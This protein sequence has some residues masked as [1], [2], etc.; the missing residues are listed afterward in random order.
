MNSSTSSIRSRMI[1][2]ACSSL[3]LAGCAAVLGAPAAAQES[4]AFLEEIVVVSQK[5]EQTLQSLP[6]AVS[7]VSKQQMDE[8]QILDVKD[9][10]FLVPS[11]RVSQLQSA[12]NTTFLIRGFG[13]GANNAG[14]EP[15]VGVFIDGVYRSR[16]AASLADLPNLER[17]EVIKGPQSTLFGKNASAGVINVVTAKPSLDGYSG[18]VQGTIGEYN[19]IMGR[20]EVNG[21][22]SDTWAWGIAANYNQRDGYFTNLET[23]SEF[24]E[25]NRYGVR[26]QLLWAPSDDFEARFIADMDEIDELCCGVANLFTAPTLLPVIGA[27]GADVVENEPFAYSQFLNFDAQNTIEN[28]GLSLQLDWNVSDNATLTSITAYRQLD[29]FENSDSDFFSGQL[30]DET[31]G[32]RINT[33]L[34]TFTQELR[35]AGSNE[36]VDW[37][38]GAFFFDEDVDQ[39]RDLT[40]GSQIR[41]YFDIL[42]GDGLAPVE[43]VANLLN[44][45]QNPGA[46]PIVF[47][48]Q[49]QG[50]FERSELANRATSL[51]AQTDIGIGERATLTLGINYTE[52]EK[53]VAV[54]INNTDQFAAIDLTGPVGQTATAGALIAQGVDPVAAGQFAAAGATTPCP[55][56]FDPN[57]PCNVTLPLQP[58]QF[59]PPFVDFPNVVETGRSD[60]SATTWTARFAYDLTE[61][62]NAYISAGTGFKATSWNLSNDSRPFASDIPALQ[63]AG[64]VTPNLTTGTRFA[65]PEDSQLLEV[66]VKGAY[67]RVAFTLAIFEQEIEN[68]QENVFQGTGFVLT[69]AGLQSST[70]VELDVLWAITENFDWSISTM[71]LDPVYDDYQG[72]PGVGGPEDFS[73]RQVPGVSETTVNTW[74]RWQFDVGANMSGFIRAEYYYESDVQVIG[75]VPADIASREVGTINASIGLRWLNGF[76]ALLWGRNI[77]N[78]EFLQSAFPTT[79][80]PGGASFSGYP[81]QPRTYGVT[82]SYFFD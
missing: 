58:L 71:F 39:S 81:N 42:S 4:E 54:R 20:A 13:N 16:T 65:S 47:F 15:S 32:N 74:A 9:L 5:R 19:Q 70:G 43:G 63:Q 79:V 30:L 10:Q 68:F 3:T 8:A 2:F 64:L 18:S 61:N 62:V 11:L 46:D 44:Q 75:N 12:G 48:G 45:A 56:P 24:N 38:L 14:V 17:I 29:R 31:G 22:I 66:G 7:V 53:D 40:F 80:Q 26:G 35:L 36:R 6:V 60:D 82:L 33:E 37:V 57:V 59:I 28:S 21:P 73:G 49:G 25:L 67:D 23:G 55:E 51:F 72:A 69:N 1:R 34:K 27:I 52:D 78:D 77:N 41:P 76:E 50:S